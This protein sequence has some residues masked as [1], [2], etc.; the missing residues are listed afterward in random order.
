MKVLIVLVF[1]AVTFG[2]LGLFMSALFG[3]TGRATVA[4]FVVVVG[5]MFGPLFLTVL[6]A[7]M[8]QGG[9]PP[10]WIL[11]P[12]PISALAAALSSSIGASGGGELFYILGGIFQ[13]GRFPDQPDQIPRPLYLL[14]LPFLRP[15]FSL[16]LYM[17]STGWSSQ[18]GVGRSSGELLIDLAVFSSQRDLCGGF[19]LTANRYENAVNQNMRGL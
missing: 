6:V 11:S 16:V 10:R 2:I 9:E 1:V 3:R 13:Y 5:L 4:S 7:A 19:A 12:S 18:R 15:L 14:R 17:L 8:R